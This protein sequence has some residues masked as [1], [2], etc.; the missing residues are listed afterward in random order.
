MGYVEVVE[1]SPALSAV[2]FVPPSVL[3]TRPILSALAAYTVLGVFGSITMAEMQPARPVSV[4]LIPASA[5]LN[6]P[7]PPP[8]PVSE[9]H[10]TC[11]VPAK[12]MAGASGSMARV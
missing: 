6:T 2:Q 5:V 3:L 11:E 10:V 7:P 9:I 1:S 4:Q 12:R 8:Q